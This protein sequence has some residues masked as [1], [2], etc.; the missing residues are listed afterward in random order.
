[1]YKRKVIIPEDSEFLN[2]FQKI[3]Q[4][5]YDVIKSVQFHIE[6]IQEYNQLI[7]LIA[8]LP[9]VKS[10]IDEFADHLEKDYT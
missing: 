6:F 2:I 10:N 9:S 1:M 8:G 7:V 5:D 3:V 4:E